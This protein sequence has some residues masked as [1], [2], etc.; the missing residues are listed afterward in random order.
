MSPAFTKNEKS[1]NHVVSAGAHVDLPQYVSL[2]HSSSVNVFLK[3]Q[4]SHH[5]RLLSSRNF[6]VGS[7]AGLLPE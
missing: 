4:F 5:Q 6:K 1:L 2:E 7:S 3:A